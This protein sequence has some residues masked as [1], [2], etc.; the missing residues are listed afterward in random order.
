M[1]GYCSNV[2]FSN[3]TELLPVPPPLL[4]L[5]EYQRR[6]RLSCRLTP[7]PSMC[8]AGEGLVTILGGLVATGRCS[9]A[10]HI[11]RAHQGEPKAPAG[12]SAFLS[13]KHFRSKE[14]DL[15]AHSSGGLFA[16]AVRP[17]SPNQGPELK[18]SGLKGV[19]C[20]EA[21]K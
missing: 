15:G 13:P 6:W 1:G 20:V 2:L 4:G 17:G 12:T 16:L 11:P 7:L 21:V 8:R 10:P 5:P 19:F 3:K 18:G 14:V 9:A